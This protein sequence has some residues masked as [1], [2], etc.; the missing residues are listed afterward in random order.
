MITNSE[1]TLVYEDVWTH[2]SGC[3]PVEHVVIGVA[4]LVE[5]AAEQLSE[6]RIVRLV[7]KLK[8]AAEIQV[9]RKFT[10]KYT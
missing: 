3:V 9:C 6:V 10:C 7:L 2:Q 4:Q 1:T 5:K 8:G